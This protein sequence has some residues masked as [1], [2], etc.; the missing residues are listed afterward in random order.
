MDR[1]RAEV[2]PGTISPL[3]RLVLMLE[4]ESVLV[5]VVDSEG[6]TAEAITFAVD[7]G[8]GNAL[9]AWITAM[10]NGSAIAKS[11]AVAT[12]VDNKAQSY[13]YFR[14]AVIDAVTVPTAD[15]NIADPARFTVRVRSREITDVKSDNTT[16]TAA[17]INQQTSRCSN[18]RVSI[19]SLPC[20]RVSKIDAFT[21]RQGERSE[22]SFPNLRVTV[23]GVDLERWQRWFRGFAAESTATVNELDG[24]LEFLA[25]SA[26]EVIGGVTLSQI[27]CV[28]LSRNSDATKDAL[29]TYVAELYVRKMMI[30]IVRT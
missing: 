3:R 15:V 19:G 14:N 18:F 12:T 11:G 27:G 4:G 9:A 17:G 1:E 30:E 8:M 10:V 22:G 21:I 23:A 2:L 16:L 13:R 7:F 24:R 5:H 26:M 25:T 6:F 28:S 29:T 20:S